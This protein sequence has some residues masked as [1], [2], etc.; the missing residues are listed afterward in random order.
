[1]RN[2][3]VTLAALV[4]CC[5][6]ASASDQQ[7][8]ELVG[9]LSLFPGYHVLTLADRNAETQS[10]L[11]GRFPKENPSVV[12]ADIDGDGNLDYALLLRNDRSS[13]AKFVVLLC[14]ADD[15]CK[16]VYESDLTGYSEEAYLRAASSGSRVAQTETIDTPGKIGPLKLSATGI[17]VIYVGQAEVVYHWNNKHKKIEA[18]QAGD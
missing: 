11:Q 10:F 2:H 5:L 14:S 12:H 1:M 17:R 4:L 3:F 7:R 6:A 18:I 13:N 8:N 15:S 9:I 16:K